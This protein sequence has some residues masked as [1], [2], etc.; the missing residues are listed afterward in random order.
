MKLLALHGILKDMEPCDDAADID[1]TSSVEHFSDSILSS[2]LLAKFLSYVTF[3]P[4]QCNDSKTLASDEQYKLLRISCPP[5]LDIKTMLH[6]AIQDVPWF[7]PAF[8]PWLVQYL[9]QIDLYGMSLPYYVEV[10][11]LLT[12]HYNKVKKHIAQFA[13][14][15]S[16]LLEYASLSWLFNLEQFQ[17]LLMCDIPST[18][19]KNGLLTTNPQST[20][21][22][23]VGLRLV[24]D[25]CMV[26]QCVK[27]TLVQFV[28]GMNNKVVTS[29]KITPLT[30]TH[31]EKATPKGGLTVSHPSQATVSTLQQTLEENFFQNQ[32][33]SLKKSCDFIA[34][35]VSSS[36][37]K[38]F[39]ANSLLNVLTEA[40]T[41]MLT[42]AEKITDTSEIRERMVP[43]VQAKCF[44]THSTLHKLALEGVDQ[45]F[46]SRVSE[47]LTLL[48]PPDS[49]KHIVTICQGVVI[50]QGFERVTKWLNSNLTCQYISAELNQEVTKFIRTG[51]GSSQCKQQTLSIQSHSETTLLPS[52]VIL[53]LRAVICKVT[54]NKSFPISK[55]ELV[56]SQAMQCLLGYPEILN[57][58]VKSICQLIIILLLELAD[59]LPEY[60]TAKV[61]TR[62]ETLFMTEALGSIFSDLSSLFPKG[63]A[64]DSDSLYEQ[65]LSYI[66]VKKNLLKS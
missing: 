56:V 22:K 19:K 66:L 65:L 52:D 20:T 9:G 25:C 30:S 10:L 17:T 37:I 5:P 62:V 45:Y 50:R 36:Y 41:T 7:V 44:T 15:E 21:S 63:E 39:R 31:T 48:L 35:R 24:Y 64:D 43:V 18:K 51:S 47:I 11:R 14:T 61:L 4:Y 3:S 33:A 28:M 29:R 6:S 1:I 38:D 49:E 55:V 12:M 53:N 27:C 34:E 46:E 58:A 54:S 2:R 60:I 40:K 32:P 16:L 13:I 59:S 23:L 42:E 57:I 8:V 26:L